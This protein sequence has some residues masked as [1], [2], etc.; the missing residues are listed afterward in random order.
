[1]NCYVEW[2]SL[3]IAINR[4]LPTNSRGTGGLAMVRKMGELNH[5]MVYNC[6]QGGKLSIAMVV[7]LK[8]VIYQQN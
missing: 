1:M 4:A 7:T 3:V 6:T 8:R 2:W 5:P